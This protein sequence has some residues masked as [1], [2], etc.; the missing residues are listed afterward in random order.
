MDIGAKLV[1]A[2][3]HVV[4]EERITLAF[5]VEIIG[6]PADFIAM[7]FHPFRKMRCFACALLVAEIARNE[8]AANREPG[9]GRENH[10]GKFSLRRDQMDLAIQFGK[11]GVQVFP[12]FLRK[13]CFRAAGATHPR[14]DLVFDSVKVRRTKEQLAHRIDNFIRESLP[15]AIAGRDRSGIGYAISEFLQEWLDI[16]D[17]AD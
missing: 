15:F 7:F 17:Q 5:E 4:A 2:K 13:C 12:L 16:C 10:V 6:Q 14:I 8:F 11:S 3:K 9:V 1:A